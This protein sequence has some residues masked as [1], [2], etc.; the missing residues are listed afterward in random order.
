MQS[1]CWFGVITGNQMFGSGNF[2]D[3]SPSWFS[4]ILKLPS[5]YLGNFKILKN[6][7]VQ[8]IPNRPPKHVITSAK[9]LT[10]LVKYFILDVWLG[11]ENI[12]DIYDIWNICWSQHFL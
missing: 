1:V 7:L 12:S 9:S 4:K 6:A 5:F 3:K 2:W 11:S 8:F 10:V